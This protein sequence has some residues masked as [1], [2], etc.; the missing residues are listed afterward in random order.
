MHAGSINTNSAAGR[1]YRLLRAEPGRWHSGWDLTMVA[2][3]TALSTRISEI[4]DQLSGDEPILA[5]RR[6]RRG[7][8]VG[9]WYRLVIEP[10]GQI[11]MRL[12]TSV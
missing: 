4:R 12:E 8:G 9:Y 1:L 2:R 7:G 10:R 3:V 5:E 11:E 6:R